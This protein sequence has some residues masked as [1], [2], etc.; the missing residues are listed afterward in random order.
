MNVPD[1]SSDTIELLDVHE[2]TAIYGD[3][4]EDLMRRASSQQ[5]PPLNQPL[6]R[7]GAPPPTMIRHFKIDGFGALREPPWKESRNI[8]RFF[9]ALVVLCPLESICLE[10]IGCFPYDERSGTFPVQKITRLLQDTGT[11]PSCLRQHPIC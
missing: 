9:H 5:Q 2:D 11:A 10:N 1:H 3:L 8:D 6:S 7:N 4:V